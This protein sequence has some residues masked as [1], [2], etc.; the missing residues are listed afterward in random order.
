MNIDDKLISEA[1]WV[2]D[3]LANAQGEADRAYYQGR[4]DQLASARRILASME[5]ECEMCSTGY[6]HQHEIEKEGK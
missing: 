3:R 6:V 2:L 5:K 1:E 4:I